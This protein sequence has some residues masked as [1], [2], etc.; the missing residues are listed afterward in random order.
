MV[1]TR[2]YSP[3]PLI[4]IRDMLLRTYDPLIVTNNSQN[5]III[6]VMSEDCGGDGGDDDND[7]DVGDDEYTNL[8]LCNL[9]FLLFLSIYSTSEPLYHIAH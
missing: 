8:Y 2:R 9:C 1:P 6:V 7:D 5:I 4:A 3:D